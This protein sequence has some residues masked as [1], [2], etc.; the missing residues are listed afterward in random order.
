MWFRKSVLLTKEREGA[1]VYRCEIINALSRKIFFSKKSFKGFRYGLSKI[2]NRERESVYI[3]RYLPKKA[4]L[5]SWQLLFEFWN[6]CTTSFNTL[7]TSFRSVGK[8]SDL[9]TNVGSLYG[10]VERCLTSSANEVL[11]KMEIW[12]KYWALNALRQA[13]NVWTKVHSLILIQLRCSWYTYDSKL[14]LEQSWVHRSCSACPDIILRW[15]KFTSLANEVL[16]LY[17][18]YC[19]Y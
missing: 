13:F 12:R 7:N 6:F 2:I 3:W 5:N 9:E 14:S 19:I 18:L 11:G 8:R 16:G 17:L 15:T 10:S 1:S 4:W